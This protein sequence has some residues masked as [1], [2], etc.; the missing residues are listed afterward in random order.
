M[1]K[2]MPNPKDDR[3]A[4]RWLDLLD[5]IASEMRLDLDQFI[6]DCMEVE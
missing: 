5:T 2:I 4:Q 1:Q 6:Q 3:E